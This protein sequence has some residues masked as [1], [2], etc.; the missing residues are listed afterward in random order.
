MDFSLTE[1]EQALKKEFEEF[2]E[3]EMKNAP[4][5]YSS[6]LEGT[7]GTE[8]GFQFHKYM[9]GKLGEKGWISLAWPKEYGGM[10]A[11]MM[12]QMI[13]GEVKGR[14][15][16]P[17]VD[18]F[19]VGMFAPTLMVGANDEQKARL[20]PPIAKGEAFYCQG[21]SEPDAGSDLAS[22]TTLAIKDGDEYVINGQKTWTTG[23]HKADYMFMLARTD[24]DSKRGKGLSVFHLSMHL[25]GIEVRPLLYMDG[26]HVYNE[27]FFKDVRVPATDLIG[28][29]GEG[30]GLTRQTMN[31]ERSGSGSFAGVKKGI[32]RLVEYTKAT[33]RNG[34]LISKDPNARRKIAQLFIGSEVGQTLGWKTAWLQKKDDMAAVVAAASGGKLFATELAQRMANYA[35]EIMGPYGQLEVSKW[36]PLEGSMVELYQ[37]C[38]GQNIYAGSNEIQRN[39]I[40]WVGL[41][42]PRLKFK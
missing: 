8:E 32:E 4:P 10:E 14:Y 31:F 42:L 1:K 41:G 34:Q 23:G 19:A 30:W 21:W 9:A 27:V 40:A 26:N 28:V 18:G 25:P 24:P 17:G 37:F 20:L 29:E 36:A 38:M 6:G 2:F 12:E 5:E 15:G 3:A 13:F 39:L 35:T 16:A 33:K 11:T 22:L 7:Y